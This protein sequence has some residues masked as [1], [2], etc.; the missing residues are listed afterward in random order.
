MIRRSSPW[1]YGRTNGPKPTTFPKRCSAYF[2]SCMW[3][4][5]RMFLI[6]AF[7][8]GPKT[9]IIAK[10]HFNKDYYQ[11]R[12]WLEAEVSPTQTEVYRLFPSFAC[13][14]T[15]FFFSFWVNN[16]SPNHRTKCVSPPKKCQLAHVASAAVNL[17]V[18][19]TS[20]GE[21]YA[22]TSKQLSFGGGLFLDCDCYRPG[23]GSSQILGNHYS[24][25]TTSNFEWR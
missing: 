18:N 23:S 15:N 10:S 3:G 19:E 4:Y 14:K 25:K 21:Y 24:I 12:D 9:E 20:C 22:V 1:T 5:L 8:R 2:S 11:N 13:E 16:R 6:N 7:E 17:S